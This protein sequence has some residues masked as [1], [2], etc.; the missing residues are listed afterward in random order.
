VINNENNENL[1]SKFGGG[2]DNFINKKPSIR[3]G[4][5]MLN[6]QHSSTNNYLNFNKL[7][8]E[9]YEKSRGRNSSTLSRI[10][11]SNCKSSYSNEN[12]YSKI[13]SNNSSNN[14]K[15]NSLTLKNDNNNNK[16]YFDK[17]KN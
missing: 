10:T 3:L 4:L 5:K 9:E 13:K 12:Y 17:K 14:I 7:P 8:S 2:E 1:P 6:N 15:K 11:I 16:N